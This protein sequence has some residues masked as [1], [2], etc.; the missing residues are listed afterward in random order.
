MRRREFITLVGGAAAA[1]PFAARAQQARKIFKIGHIESGSPS[2][3]PYLL[4]AFQQGL[5]KLGYVE[6]EN[7]F[8]ERRYAE[9]VEERLPQLATELVQFGVDVIFAI[10]PP[11]ALAAAKATSTIPI[12]FVGGGDPVAAG[13][14]K[15]LSHPGGNVTGLTL[16]TVELAAKRIQMLKEVVS[17]ASR[18]AILWNPNNLINKLEL[19][20]AN[21][22]GR[23][24]GLTLLPVEIRTLDD[25]D[26][27]F[28]TMT[29]ER[30]EAV[31]I[32]SSPLTFP[33]RARLARLASKA[34]LPTL[35]PLREY[36]ETGFLVSYGPSYTD[37]CRRAATYV[38]QILKG[39]KPA[40]LPVQLPTTLEMVINLKAARA[41][42]YSVAPELLARADEVI[43]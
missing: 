21:M 27:A 11:Q 39:A 6:G 15:S 9:G 33:N 40:D 3:S 29:R 2:S 13:L 10:G 32:L 26:G 34:R 35:V 19:N 28:D 1:W 41:I 30:A 18:M 24:L 12:V 25:V 8:I 16:V 42:G 37:H 5:R 43:E 36:V 38:D 4:A 23:S 31:L 22:A 20:E 14:I 17:T 7:L